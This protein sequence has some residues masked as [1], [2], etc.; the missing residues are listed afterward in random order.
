MHGLPALEIGALAAICA[1][2]DAFAVGRPGEALDRPVA[3]RQAPRA[4]TCP[5]VLDEQVRVPVDVA[6]SVVSPVGAGDHARQRRGARR[7][8]AD[9]EARYGI[10]D[11]E[12][13]PASARRLR[14]G[15]DAVRQRRQLLGLATL[16]RH[17]PDLFV[18]QEEHAVALRRHLRRGVAHVA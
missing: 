7:Q 13:Q 4:S 1:E 2:R 3:A 17:C 14:E 16:E 12:R 8:R 5:R 10:G 9:G 11:G 6:V 15:A 18:A